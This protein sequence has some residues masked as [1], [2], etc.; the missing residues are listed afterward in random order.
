MPAI[1]ANGIE[2]RYTAE[3]KGPDLV[4]S[5]SLACDVSMWDEQ[6]AALAGSYRV[7]R[8]DTRGHG[9]SEA[10]AA[11]YTLELLADDLKALLDALDIRRPHF[12]GLS[13]GGMIGQTCALKYPGIFRSLILCDTTSAYA[14]NVAPVWEERI[15]TARTQGM[16]ALVDATLG[17]WFT[18]PFRRA[19]P[20][21]VKRFAALIS[22]TPV[23]GYAGCSQALLSID[24]TAR[25]RTLALPALVIV[26]EEDPGTPVAMARAIH[27]NLPGSELAVIRGAAHISNVEQPEEFNRVLLRFLERNKS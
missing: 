1:R 17:R 9:R 27:E 21:I 25:L 24:V 10:T 18:E 12:A 26:G 22:A 19:R 3:G 7:I 8:Y 23:E 2:M 5:H 11:P 15:R 16:P 6:A 14:A 13:M 20:D 4:L